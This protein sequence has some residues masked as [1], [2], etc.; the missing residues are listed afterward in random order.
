M[1]GHK[2]QP[3]PLNDET[4]HIL[5]QAEASINQRLGL[6]TDTDNEVYLI[7]LNRGKAMK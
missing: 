7:A 1:E 4:L 5:K 3:A 2:L 6:E